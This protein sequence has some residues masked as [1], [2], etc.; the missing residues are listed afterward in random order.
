MANKE[1]EMT[2]SRNIDRRSYDN[3]NFF[4]QYIATPQWNFGVNAD[5]R[6]INDISNAGLTSDIVWQ[7]D[8]YH[9]AKEYSD[10]FGV[11]RIIDIGCGSALKLKNLFLD[12]NLE[13]FALDFSGS[14]TAAI[15]NYPT[16]HHIDCDL[17][18]W[19]D[20]FELA[21]L[22][23]DGVP[24]VVIC[25]NI[26]E[27]LQDPRPLLALIRLILAS[28]H[29]NRSFISTPDRSR[30]GYQSLT[31]K[32]ANPS[33]VR[34]WTNGELRS[35][36][37]ASGFFV[38]GIANV[39]ANIHDDKA[40]LLLLECSFDAEMY[41]EITARYGIKNSAVSS[42]ML[43]TEY[44]GLIS[45]GGIGT[46]VANWHRSNVGS[47]VFTA[48]DFNKRDTEVGDTVFS[49]S[50]LVDL[51]KVD[52]VGTADILLEALVQFLFLFPD[53]KE[54]HFQDYLGIGMRISQ[55]KRAGI[56]PNSITTVV[57]CHGNQHYLENAN[58]AWSDFTSQEAAV[59]E[60]ISIELADLVVFPSVF[61]RNFY[62]QS[63]IIIA[64]NK[65]IM[66]PY[67]Y[68]NIE[69]NS[70]EYLN[71]KKIVFVGKFMPMK[72]FDLFCSS[73][74]LEF[75][76]EL[77]SKGIE[78]IV[79][80]GRGPKSGFYNEKKIRG[81]FKLSV[82][83]DF[84]LTKLVRYISGNK[85]S[86][87]FV[88][89]YR[90]DNFPLAVYDVIANGG[91]LL[92][93]NAGGVP[94]MFK[95]KAWHECLVDLNVDSLRYKI[96]E[97][98]DMNNTEKLRI[99][100]ELIADLCNS[101]NTVY[102]IQHLDKNQSEM[103]KLTSTI[104]IPFYNTEISEYIDLLKAINQQSLRPSE[105]IIVNDASD[106]KNRQEMAKFTDQILNIPYRI[107]DH[108][109][110]CGLSAARNT[111]LYACTT[112][113][114]LNVDSDDV[115]KNDWVKTIVETLGRNPTAAAAVPYL[116][117]FDAGME[118]N[119]FVS[120]GRYVYR[121]IGDGFVTSQ[122]KNDLGH[123]NSGYRVSF[124]R[125]IGGWNA[126]SKAKYEDW[127]FFL[128]IIANGLRIAIIPKVTCLYR[129]RKDSMARTYSNWP[130]EARL[131]QTN[132][133]LS[134]FEAL[135]LQRLCR[136]QRQVAHLQSYENRKLSRFINAVSA[137]TKR[138]PILHSTLRRMVLF[139]WKVLIPIKNKFR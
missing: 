81:A 56:L 30:L 5:A 37:I 84:D 132:A 55:A 134:R 9:S 106:Y 110:N 107:I 34:E 39:Q 79:F 130:G 24:T 127:A 100:N 93:G 73:F 31:T 47:A 98:I 21:K 88:E 121:P 42:V 15:E 123:A 62:L 101:N 7:P 102:N 63:G 35:L 71:V 46:F 14:L 128:N 13:I 112:D 4:H 29:K 137:Q 119:K 118:F 51:S 57:H 54:I 43:T 77:K 122:T 126:D 108:K 103:D 85:E 115:P 131:Y 1:S 61:L 58:Y 96:R 52:D 104:M 133:G 12:S 109:Y 70:L 59:K 41:G 117:A 3:L 44:P 95:V 72:G 89:P 16:A 45:S 40:S 60:K 50:D 114:I 90:G 74:N 28:N 75:C 49:P 139:G 20:V 66:C 25:A 120:K 53:I 124:A 129:V 105:V 87:L 48:F 113:V 76:N 111:A 17:T 125:K 32:P 65:I 33:H 8:T 22:F 82:Y 135:Q 97:F 38:E 23:R 92:A 10:A 99:H 78:E 136:Y 36:L 27:H 83:T 86:S 68:P 18:S 6:V 11:K 26:I 19:N 94:E 67:K 138:V 116:E 2:E 80:I 64:D 91:M 69:V